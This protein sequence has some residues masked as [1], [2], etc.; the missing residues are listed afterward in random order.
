M[1][2]GTIAPADTDNRAGLKTEAHQAGTIPDVLRRI[3]EMAPAGRTSGN[4]AVGIYLHH[5]ALDQ[6]IHYRSHRTERMV[7]PIPEWTRTFQAIPMARE[8]PE[9]VTWTSPRLAI[10]IVTGMIGMIGKEVEDIHT[11]IQI[12]LRRTGKSFPT[13]ILTVLRLTEGMRIRDAL[14]AGVRA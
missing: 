8:D 13:E 9:T 4:L 11:E 2:T 14:G 12:V 1:E 3:E 7:V 5:Q 10:V 6:G